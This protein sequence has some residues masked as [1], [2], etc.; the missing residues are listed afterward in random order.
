METARIFNIERFATEDGVGIRT[1]VFLKGC[2]MRCKWCANPESQEFGKEILFKSRACIDCG[3]CVE[4]CEQKAID[5]I[6]G[7]GYITNSQ[8]CNYCGKCIEECFNNARSLVGIDYTVEELIKEVLRDKEYYQI[9]GG[10]ITFSGGEP[11]FH[12][13]FIKQCSKILKKDNINI[14]VETCG[15]VDINNIKNVCD[16][17]D[18]IFYDI[19]HMNSEKH[20]ELTGKDNKLIINNLIWLSKKFKGKLSVRYPYIP[21]CN[22]D[23]GV[24]RGFL[25]FI[26]SL[27]NIEEVVFLPYHRLG[28]PKYSGLGRIYEM[29]DMKSLNPS[30]LKSISNIF[31]DYDIKIKIQ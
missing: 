5:L 31:K 6:D 22:D 9:S 4:I 14:L 16:Y 30:E 3:K 25:D 27:D 24:I 18:Y 8:L 20:K 29:G 2:Q 21:N 26:Q 23:I 15:Y 1:V 7:F 13:Q 10:G 12:S 19:K 17:V 28:M 11:F